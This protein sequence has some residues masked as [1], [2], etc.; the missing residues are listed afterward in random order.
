MVERDRA[1]ARLQAHR[2]ELEALGVLHAALFGSIARGDDRPDS[3]IDVMV[4]VDPVKV[5]SILALGRIQS[6]LERI[7]GRPVDVARRSSLRPSV[8][9]EA[10]RD[11]IH[12]F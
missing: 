10:A 11:A 7:M 12:A 9:D 8:A 6:R 3:D 5:R 4:D 2:N 1:I